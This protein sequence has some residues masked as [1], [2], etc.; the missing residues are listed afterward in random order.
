MEN[1]KIITFLEMYKGLLNLLD[2]YDDDLFNIDVKAQFDSLYLNIKNNPYSF[3]KNGNIDYKINQKFSQ[4]EIRLII[5][6]IKN[7]FIEERK[8]HKPY[9]DFKRGESVIENSKFHLI[10]HFH[11]NNEVEVN[12]AL[13]FQD[14]AI[15]KYENDNFSLIKR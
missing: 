7:M 1:K 10:T 14:I 15:E 12:D 5:N 8:I 9:I 2:N 6:T 11:P 13:Y 3:K 4:E